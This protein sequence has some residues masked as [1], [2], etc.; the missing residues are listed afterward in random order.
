MRPKKLTKKHHFKRW[1]DVLTEGNE[2]IKIEAE[3]DIAVVMNPTRSVALE[4]TLE[5]ALT[6]LRYH[7]AGSSRFCPWAIAIG[8]IR[9]QLSHPY[10]GV[11]DVQRDTVYVGSKITKKGK[12]TECYR[13]RLSSAAMKK[14]ISLNDRPDGPAKVA[15]SLRRHGSQKGYLRPRTRSDWTKKGG[16]GR[17]DG[18]RGIVINAKQR[19]G[20]MRRHLD[21]ISHLGEAAEGVST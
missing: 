16:T 11:C 6:S 7:G 14:L 1:Q 18:S 20:A 19:K 15:A 2:L 5:D 21:Y 13:Y 17:T 12:V 4:L 3:P 8:R 9:S 10:V